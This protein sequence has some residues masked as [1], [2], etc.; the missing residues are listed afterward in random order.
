MEVQSRRR[1]IRIWP[2]GGAARE[3]SSPHGPARRCSDAR[4]TPAD[5]SSP[6]RRTW[7]R[8][9]LGNR[10]ALMTCTIPF[11]AAISVA[12]MPAAVSCERL[13]VAPLSIV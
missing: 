10:T 3:A 8:Y 6:R 7:T 4:R 5:S 11:V 13:R 12:A 1:A 9:R 2:S